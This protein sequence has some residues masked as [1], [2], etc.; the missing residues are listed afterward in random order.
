M[1][2]RSIISRS[3]SVTDVRGLPPLAV[4]TTDIPDAEHVDAPPVV[5]PDEVWTL[6]SR[7]IR[8]VPWE[9]GVLA[10]MMTVV[11]L[12]LA[13]PSTTGA[14]QWQPVPSLFAATG[15]P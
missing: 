15:G 2:T 5:V 7:G 8:D 9:A 1:A 4:T 12:L 13:Q 3:P 14:H 6:P 10:V 11:A